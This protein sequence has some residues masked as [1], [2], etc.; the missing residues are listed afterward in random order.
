MALFA[1]ALLGITLTL[2][3]TAGP[4]LER[5]QWAVH[6]PGTALI[7]WISGLI[8]IMAAAVGLLA[9][10]LLWPPAPLHE[11]LE[12]WHECLPHHPRAGLIA[13][14]VATAA[15]LAGCYHRLS[16]GIPR[17]WRAVFH[18]RRHREM[19][20]LVARQDAEH[21]D[22]LVLDHPVPVAYCIPSRHRSIVV[23]RGTRDRLDPDHM[24]AVLAHERT[25]LRQ[26]HHLLLLLL[27]LMHSLL[28]WLPTVRRAQ[29]RIPQLLEMI[30]D[31]AAVRRHGPGPLAEA[32]RRLVPLPGP[33]GTLAAT[34]PCESLLAHRLTRLEAAP[35]SH[36]R[37][38]RALGWVTAA[39][40]TAG[41]LSLVAIALA[42]VPA[43]C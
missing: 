6:Q 23:S 34:G 26:R 3:V 7:C 43:P 15:L 41:S 42:A 9:L 21:L 22:V 39:C 35:G 24:A 36:P 40:T 32:L 38:V 17:V 4:L 33:A 19:V 28:P 31:D 27:D 13:A 37:G 2:G 16:V 11:L 30:A 20:S 1:L 5:G 12:R 29:T 14:S 10:A 18:R 8:G 25:H